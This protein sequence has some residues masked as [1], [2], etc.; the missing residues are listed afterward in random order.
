[1]APAKNFEVLSAMAE[2]NLNIKLSPVS[3][4]SNMKAV[5]KGKDTDITIGF[6]GNVILQIMDGQLVGGLLL[7]DRQQF[8]EVKKEL[9]AATEVPHGA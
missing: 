8:E 3:N 5:H 6:A 2:R 7:Y 9:E 1:M 4:I